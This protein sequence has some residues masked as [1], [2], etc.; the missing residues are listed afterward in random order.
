MESELDFCTYYKGRQ[1]QHCGKEIS[2]QTHKAQIFCKREVLPDGSIKNCK[3]DHHVILRNLRN[4]PY[5]KIVNHYK[6][7]DEQIEKLFDN[8]DEKISS[9]L[10]NR[11]GIKLHRPVEF[12]VD[13]KSN[14]Y[15]FYFT[16]Y[17]FKQISD[18]D[19]KIFKHARIF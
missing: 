8:Y 11:Y 5:K 15:T 10:I 3:D 9:E 16:R 17:A 1:C 7:M 19:F 13:K 14:F 18:T 6:E 12:E 2:D 4:L